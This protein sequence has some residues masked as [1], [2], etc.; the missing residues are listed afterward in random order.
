M[1]LP[2]LHPPAHPPQLLP[3]PTSGSRPR[4]LPQSTGAWRRSSLP[5][6][7]LPQLHLDWHRVC[8][9]PAGA[10]RRTAEPQ[11]ERDRLRAV[12]QRA[13]S[14]SRSNR[15]SMRSG[16]IQSTRRPARQPPGHLPDPP[17]PSW[18]QRRTIVAPTVHN[19]EPTCNRSNVR[20]GVDQREQRL[21]DIVAGCRGNEAPSL[22]YRPRA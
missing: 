11:Q 19:I 22:S 12:C 15:T 16:H 10:P 18:L 3:T 14:R 5:A 6:R 9:I 20:C 2:W 7:Y 17:D 21:L 13:T 8:W 1:R 4:T